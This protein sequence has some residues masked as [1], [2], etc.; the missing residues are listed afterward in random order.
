MAIF[1]WEGVKT[2]ERRIG[3]VVPTN[4]AK[5]SE[6]QDEWIGHDDEAIPLGRALAG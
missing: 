3:R 6:H 1:A 2:N 5:S 4:T